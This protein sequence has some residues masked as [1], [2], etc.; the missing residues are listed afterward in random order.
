MSHAQDRRDARPWPAGLRWVA[1]L[2]VL[3]TLAT[4]AVAERTLTLASIE[5]DGATRTPLTTVERYL[6]LAPGDTIT[7][8]GLIAAVAQL[9]EGR[10]FRTVAFYTRPG[11]MRGAIILVLEVAEHRFDFRWAAGN[12]D[13]DGWYL[14]PVMLAYDNPFGRGGAADMQL[15]VGFR[16]SG[17]VARYLQP[18]AADGRTYWGLALHTLST[19][20]PYFA[21]GVEYRHTVYFN[22]LDAVLGRHVSPTRTIE[23]G[24]TLEGADASDEAYVS[25]GSAD[26]RIGEGDR[27]N[28]RDLPESVR[29]ATGGSFRTILSLDWRHDTRTTRRKAGSPVGGLWG[30]VKGTYTLQDGHSHPGLQADLRAYGEVPGGVLAARMRAA[31][32]GDRALFYDRLYLGGLYSVRGFPTHSLSAPGGDTWLWSGSLEYRSTI[33]PAAEGTRLAGLFFLDVGASGQDDAVDPYTGIAVSVGYGV[34]W[35]VWWLDWL[36][37]DVGFPLTDRPLDQDF[38]VSASLG[39]SF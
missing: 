11:P 15:R 14:A 23:A 28:A 8:D 10:L 20:R 18:R 16:H 36:G 17:F 39:W 29:A 25:L 34:R 5:L 35:K 6:G 2:I 3:A 27:V 1:V 13:L 22:G 19:D 7:Q 33:L 26:G 30:R 4:G 32:V 24:V 21:D 9:R 31:W 38:Q 12:T 37:L